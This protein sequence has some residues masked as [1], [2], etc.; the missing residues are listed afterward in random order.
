MRSAWQMTLD[1]QTHAGYEADLQELSPTQFS[2]Y[3][4]HDRSLL[5]ARWIAFRIC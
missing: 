1:Q 4:T 5:A 2:P 3:F